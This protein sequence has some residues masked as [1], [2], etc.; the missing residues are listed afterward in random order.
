MQQSPIYKRGVIYARVS[1]PTQDTERQVHDL[2]NL[3]SDMG[4]FIVKSF[5]EKVSGT[6]MLIERNVLK[7][8]LDFCTANDIEVILCSE[9]SRMGRIKDEVM[10]ILTFCLAKGIDIYF[11]KERLH[12]FQGQAT[13][14]VSILEAASFAEREV[15]NFKFRINSGRKL[16]IEQGVKMGRPNGTTKSI[17]KYETQY[18]PVIERL[19]QGWKMITTYRWTQAQGLKCSYT[20]IKKLKYIFV[21]AKQ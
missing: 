1:K 2:T 14:V 13:Q 15:D 17:E 12:L 20:T 5:S 6:K 16:A 11:Q 19:K 7:E 8:C 9:V 3:A 10:G 4:I 18:R 21:D